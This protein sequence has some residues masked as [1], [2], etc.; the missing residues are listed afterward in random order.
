MSS[1]LRSLVFALGAVLFAGPALASEVKILSL[2]PTVLFPNREPL[3]QI[4]RLTVL[5]NSGAAIRGEVVITIAGGATEKLPEFALAPNQT[6]LDVLV[7]DISAPASVKVEFRRAGAVVAAHEQ[8]WQPQRKWKVHIVKSSHEDIG[9]ENYI[10]D[11]QHEIADFIEYG[12][13]LSSPGSVINAKR[14]EEGEVAYHYTLETILF[15]RNYIEE[16]GEAAWRHFVETEL[17]P[18]HLSLMGAPSGVHSHWMDYEE[19]ARMGYPARRESRDRFGLDLKTFMIVDNPSLSWSGAQVLANSGFKYVARWGQQ[20]RSGGNNDYATTKLPAVFWW[21][22]PDGK[23]RILFSWRNH[24]SQGFWVGQTGTNKHKIEL[25]S[26]DVSAFLREVESGAALG[27]YPYDALVTPEY[28]DHAIPYFSLRLLP[29]WHEKYAYPR[30]MVSSPTAFFTYIE[31]KYGDSLPVLSGDLNNFSA[32]YATIDPESQDWKRR[33]ARLLPATEGL[34]AI[35]GAKDASFALAVSEVERIYTRFFDYDEHCWPTSPLVTDAQLFNA[36]WV[37]KHEARRALD[38]TEALFGRASAALGAQI[39]SPGPGT[40]AVYNPLVH[41]RT[42]LVQLATRVPAVTDL[43]TGKVIPCEP[44]AGGGSTF[45]A[46]EIPALGYALFRPE[47]GQGKAPAATGLTADRHSIANSYYTVRFDPENGAVTSIVD[48]TTGRELIDQAAP[49]RANQLVYIHKNERLAKEGFEYKV[50]KAVRMES[51]LGPTQ[52]AFDVWIDDAKLGGKIRQTVT[53]TAGVKRVDFANHLESIDVMWSA[54]YLDRYRDNLYYA[55]P[56]AVPEGQ[57]RAEYP[58]GVV[59]PYD[60][61]LRWGSHDYLY[62]NRWVDI[63]NAAGGIT[64]ASREAGTFSFGEIRYNELAV[65]YKPSKSWLFSYAWSNRM[66]GLITLGPDD[67]NAS[68]HYSLTSHEG[69]WNSGAAVAHGWQTASPLL[70]VPVT[71]G[72]SAP[73]TGHQRSFL[74]VSV[75][76]V[77]LSV[78]KASAVAGQGWVARFVETAGR[79]TEFE[80]DASALGVN[81]AALCN[82]VEDDSG[83]LA[84]RNGRLRVS[85]PAFGFATVRLVAGRA[86]GA[87]GKVTASDITDSALRLTWSGPAG[88]AYNVYRSD[89]PDAPATVY[90]LIARTAAP[91]FADRGLNLSTKYYYRVAAVNA[92]NLQGPLSEKFAVETSAVNRTAPSPVHEFGVVR[93]SPDTLFVYW[94]KN[95][96]SDVARYRIFRGET[97]DFSLEGREPV[98]LHEADKYF[99]QIFRDTG[100]EPGRTYYYRVQPVDWAANVQPDSPLAS[101]TTPLPAGRP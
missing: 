55:F 19:I 22:G 61:Q 78:L 93:R 38:G 1:V 60:D 94:R 45:L 25:A 23:S 100:L 43:R 53:L 67:C 11:K 79:A 66:A 86:P 64:L 88:A 95:P 75:P 65:D 46:P 31:E 35:A 39:A 50:A 62:A 99:L 69:D 51:R 87:V 92:A 24:Y 85:I 34:G 73:W 18:G 37:K 21:Q 42:D 74:T 14:K 27:P 71:G 5:N 20:W 48:K 59:R 32:D 56:F 77:E 13:E 54:D 80:V 63:S 9:Y 72:A 96:E 8:L 15:Q 36:N 57:F 70:V 84:V 7:P 3:A 2:E 40:F 33:A 16:R 52:V 44:A 12:R 29:A 97:P 41:P 89:D 6:T 68:F 98:A 58:G 81:E 17:K 28:T 30:I 76:N 91:E 90:S 49:Y 10:F 82:L 4:A 26:G 83:P 47:P 101:A